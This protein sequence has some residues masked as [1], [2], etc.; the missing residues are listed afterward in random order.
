[1]PNF[2][3]GCWSRKTNV[4]IACVALTM[5]MS[6]SAF[7]ADQDVEALKK[8]LADQRQLLEIQRQQLDLLLANQR[9]SEALPSTAEDE[10]KKIRE[11]SRGTVA[12]PAT[13]NSVGMSEGTSLRIYGVADVSVTNTNSGYGRKTR[14]DGGGGYSASRLGAQITRDLGQGLQAIGLAEAGAQFTTGSVG[15]AAPTSGINASTPSTGG[16]PGTGPQLFARQMFGGLKGSL[17]QLTIG[18]Q[19]TGSYVADAVVG[20]AHG[21]GFYGNSA[22]FTPLIGGMPTRVNNS[23]VWITPKLGGF[24]GW[25][26]AFGG[27]QNNVSGPTA[28]GATTTTDRAGRGIDLAAI[29]S[30][31][32]LTSAATVWTVRN[33]S[34]VTAGETG[35]A[36]KRGFQLQA[37]Y[38]FKI[39]KLYGGFVHGTISGGNYQN[40]TKT[41]S[42]ASAYNFGLLVPVGA[43]SF[44]FSYTNFDDRSLQNKD[45]KLLGASWWYPLLKDTN[46]YASLGRQIN[47]SNATYSLADGGDLVGSVSRPGFSPTGI[48]V[49]FN[50]TF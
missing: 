13:T 25:I 36:T 26:T 40:V 1:M 9:Q 31:G 8:E 32:C 30:V 29:Y 34:Y 50:F 23:L 4:A 3:I 44:A 19:Y 39:F 35:L 41:L 33:N 49:G 16:A 24:Y 12:P 11:K 46:V 42:D 37:N 20:V 43:S 45:G 14:I 48:Q 10:A 15:G 22:T 28:V 5:A 7:S 27:A 21:D 18:R 47:N 17:G 38:D 6:T 2:T